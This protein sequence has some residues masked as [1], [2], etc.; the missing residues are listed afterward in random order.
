MAT[1]TTDTAAPTNPQTISNENG[2]HDIEQGPDSYNTTDLSKAAHREGFIYIDDLVVL[3]AREIGFTEKHLPGLW[4][5]FGC[6]R[7]RG[8]IGDLSNQSQRRKRWFTILYR[9]AF[10]FV[11]HP[12]AD[13]SLT[14]HGGRKLVKKYIQY[15]DGYLPATRG[16]LILTCKDGKL[17]ESLIKDSNGLA[18]G[19]SATFDDFSNLRHVCFFGLDDL[20]DYLTGY[21]E[22]PA[23]DLPDSLFTPV[24][25]SEPS[26]TNT[27][28][29]PA[30]LPLPTKKERKKTPDQRAKLKCREIAQE[31]WMADPSITI[32]DIIM[33]D[34]I[35]EAC[36]EIGGKSYT[37][38]ILRD[39]IN[40]LCPN[41]NG[42]RRSKK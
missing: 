35:E 42:G 12:G 20:R 23:E 14:R 2:T 15:G 1:L 13:D 22:I 3:F 37:E 4:E 10:G 36:M 30:A 9:L 40:D 38:K 7:R 25:T 33:I 26:T 29:T 32:A 21:A 28:G 31:K 6:E 8:P 27:P 41:R 39:W 34:E 18:G 24:V 11:D 19:L 16:D 5:K 17:R